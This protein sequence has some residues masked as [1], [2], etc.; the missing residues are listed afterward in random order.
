MSYRVGIGVGLTHG[1]V[2]APDPTIPPIVSGLVANLD[3]AVGVTRVSGAVSLWTD[4]TSGFS[5]AQATAGK[6]PAYAAA[7]GPN[8]LPSITYVSASSQQLKGATSP[9]AAGSDRTSFIVLVSAST[10]NPKGVIAFRGNFPTL[11]IRYDANSNTTGDENVF[12][13]FGTYTRDASPHIIDSTH[14]VGSLDPYAVDGALTT[15]TGGHVATNDNGTDGF[16]VGSEG[17]AGGT[18]FFDGQIVKV[19]VY[20]RV[21]TSGELTSVRRYLGSRYAITVP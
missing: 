4:P 11:S 20:S 1:G 3:S 14:T 21:L 12:N 13:N 19:L 10:G 16:C 8:G 15:Q 17:F 5:V 2:S 9:V 18:A 7:T 6:R